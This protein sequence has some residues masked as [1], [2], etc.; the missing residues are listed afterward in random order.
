M[1]ATWRKQRLHEEIAA[2]A[3]EHAG[4]ELDLDQDLERAGLELLETGRS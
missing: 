2:W 3:S 1:T 4:T